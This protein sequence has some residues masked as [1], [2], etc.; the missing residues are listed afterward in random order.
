M[1]GADE[2][3]DLRPQFRAIPQGEREIIE[4]SYEEL[5]HGEG[6]DL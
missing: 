5:S 2:F 6:I 4:L 3:P 1:D